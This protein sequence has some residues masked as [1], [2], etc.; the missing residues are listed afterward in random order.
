MTGFQSRAVAGRAAL[1]DGRRQPAGGA[2]HQ[3]RRPAPARLLAPSA[4][5]PVKQM[6]RL[7]YR[8]GLTLDA[9]HAGRSR[10]CAAARRGGDADV[11]L[12]LDFLAAPRAASCADRRMARAPRCAWRWWPARPRATCWPACCSAAL[13]AA[14]ARRCRPPASAGRRWRRRASRPGGRTTSWR[15]AATSRCCATTARSSASATQLAER[16]LARAARRLHRRRRARLQP[17]PG[18]AAAR[19]AGI[20][21]DPLRQPVDLGL[22][23]RAGRE[24]RP[25]RSTMCCACFRSSRRCCAQHGIAATYV[26]HPLADAIPLEVPRA[27]SRA[28][29]RPGR[30][31]TPWWRCCPAAGAPRSSYIAPRLPAGRGAAA[32][33]AARPALRAAGGAG[34]ARRWSSRCWPQHAPGVPDQLLDG[35]S[36]EALAACDVTLVASGTATLEAALFK[37]PMVIAYRMHCAELA[38]DE[39]HAA[40]SP[41][42]ACPTSCAA[43]SWC[44]S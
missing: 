33:A 25:Q 24:D 17:R 30:A 16:L 12:M 38:A 13:R 1:H 42:S 14:L 29:A 40:T 19:R 15:C 4:S 8:D 43:S 10:R 26:G 28:R 23:R 31:T 9:G 20:K 5:P 7:L 32:P 36:H 35:Q 21:T 22:A 18:S 41:G 3:R 44:P 34:P 2:R 6:H 37:R 39:A 11:A 27:A